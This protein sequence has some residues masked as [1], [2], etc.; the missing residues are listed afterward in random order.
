MN[1]QGKKNAWYKTPVST[2]EIQ[3]MESGMVGQTQGREVEEEKPHVTRMVVKTYEMHISR[4]FTSIL[5][6]IDKRKE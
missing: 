5:K 6:K 4:Q 2:C 3:C 1:L